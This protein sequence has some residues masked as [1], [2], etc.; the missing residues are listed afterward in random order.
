MSENTAPSSPRWGVTL[1]IVVGL[2]FAIGIGVLLVAFRSIIGPLLL[3]IILAYL[4]HPLAVRL[5]SIT[6]LNWR[7]S[8]S[9]VFI[10]LLVVIAGLFTAVGVAVVSQIE[11]LVNLVENFVNTTLPQMLDNL[12][13]MTFTLGPWSFN[14]S[15]FEASNLVDQALNNL[16]S[17]IG[18]AT[19]VIEVV[20]T[21]AIGTVGWTAFIVLVSYFVLADAGRVPDALSF[22]TIP[23]YDYDIRRLSRE[24]GRTWNIY[25]RGQFF[26]ILMVILS[27]WLL[28]SI[29]GLR[30]ALAIALLTG[31]ARFIPYIGPLITNLITFVV[32]FFQASNYFNLEPIVYA[33]IVVGLAIVFDQVFDNLITPRILGESLGVPPAAVLIAALILAQSIGFVGLVLA[34]P[35]LASLRLLIRYMGRKMFDLDPWPEPEPTSPAIVFPW[36]RFARWRQQRLEKSSGEQESADAPDETPR[37]SDGES[38]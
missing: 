14:L 37:T 25:V 18:Q 10:L 34:A 23:G 20:L 30:Y 29:L 3:A 12:D 26:I 32:A 19:G 5:S 16:R 7:A 13:Q 6:R 21:G 11:S 2:S 17:V 28:F 36:Q 33:L 22:I 8:V 9:L 1:K 24:L 4:L 31:L 15:Q 38:A 35:M 27:A